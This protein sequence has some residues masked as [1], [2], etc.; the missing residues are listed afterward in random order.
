MRVAA[1]TQIPQAM[2]HRPKDKEEREPS[3]K[4]DGD[5][6]VCSGNRRNFGLIDAR[7]EG[8]VDDDFAFFSESLAFC[9]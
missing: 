5:E 9:K 6:I 1:A 7:Y 2:G 8:V 3:R 4:D